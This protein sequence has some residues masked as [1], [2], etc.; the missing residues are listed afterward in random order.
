[1]KDCPID[2]NNAND[3]A[4][5]LEEKEH[6]RL[7]KGL[8][9]CKNSTEGYQTVLTKSGFALS[10]CDYKKE[11]LLKA[12]ERNLIQTLFVS[13]R[14]LKADLASFDVTTD[15]RKRFTTIFLIGFRPFNKSS[16]RKDSIYTVIFNWENVYFR[17]HCQ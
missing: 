1:M 16:L 12:K 17:M 14:I 9:E 13:K 3:Y 15:H 6:C 7:C 8:K 5:Y 2:L 4:L 11:M 10:P